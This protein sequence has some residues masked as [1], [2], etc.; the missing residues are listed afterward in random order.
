M[1]SPKQE[2]VEKARL[3]VL[4]AMRELNATGQLEFEEQA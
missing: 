4:Q 3:E 1:S 2:D